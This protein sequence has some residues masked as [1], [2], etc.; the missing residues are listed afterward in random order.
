MSMN[1]LTQILLCVIYS[2]N[3]FWASLLRVYYCLSRL[4]FNLLRLNFWLLTWFQVR[5][6]SFGT[7]YH[8]PSRWPKHCLVEFIA[9]LFHA[10]LYGRFPVKHTFQ[11]NTNTGTQTHAQ[12]ETSP[13]YPIARKK[14]VCCD[15]NTR[16]VCS[17]KCD[18]TQNFHRFFLKFCLL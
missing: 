3:S 10:L 16:T 18:K 6:Q 7:L 15:T 11:T 8:P 2:F 5:S 12:T 13:A 17:A 9:L 1:P 4:T 14:H